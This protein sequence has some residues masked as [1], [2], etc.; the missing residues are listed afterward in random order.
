M[1]FAGQAVFRAA[2]GV[3]FLTS[4]ESE[5]EKVWVHGVFSNKASFWVSGD[6]RLLS[7][8][9]PPALAHLP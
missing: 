8:C 9:P 5:N 3:C 6:P 1:A 2:L 4:W 7:Q